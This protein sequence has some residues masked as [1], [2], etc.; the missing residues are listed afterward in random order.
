MAAEN[1]YEMEAP[2]DKTT[3]GWIYQRTSSPL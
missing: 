3:E 1:S 2:K